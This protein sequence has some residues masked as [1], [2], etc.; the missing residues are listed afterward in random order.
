MADT[1]KNLLFSALCFGLLFVGFTPDNISLAAESIK[2]SASIM[3]TARVEFPIGMTSLMPESDQ[4]IDISIETGIDS[5]R[6]LHFPNRESLIIS[7]DSGEG[8]TDYNIDNCES[9]KCD[10]FRPGLSSRTVVLNYDCLSAVLS[11]RS[12][13]IITIIDSG[14]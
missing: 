7:I 5:R 14:I 3:A 11:D 9:A 13:V 12:A 10:I 1:A 4:T 6:L 8:Q 2:T